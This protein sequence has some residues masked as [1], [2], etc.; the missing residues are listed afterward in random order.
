[1]GV[2]ALQVIDMQGRRGM[3]GKTLEKFMYQIDIKLTNSSAWVFNS[4]FD[5]GPAGKIDHDTR[6]G[7][8]QRNVG[9]PITHD[10]FFIAQG[11]AIRLAKRYTYILDGMVVV[12]MQVTAG[13]NF[14][15]NKAMAGYLIEHMFEKWDPGFKTGLAS[16]I[17]VNRNTDLSFQCV[18]GDGGNSI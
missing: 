9:M 7:F 1:M 10:A 15:I 12:N 11:L 3:I 2:F 4:I 18:P 17:Q 14:K 8:I 13:F 5:P 16:A 6:Q